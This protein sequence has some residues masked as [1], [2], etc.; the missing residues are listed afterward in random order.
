MLS[1]S[2]LFYTKGVGLK[3]IP[4]LIFA[5]LSTSLLFVVAAVGYTD[6]TVSEA[7]AMIDSDP[8]LLILDVRNQSEYYSGH[9]REARLIPVYDLIHRLEEL[10][11]ND[12][13]LVYS[14]SGERGSAASQVLVDNGFLHV[15]NL[16]GG[17]MDWKNSG[18]D[19]YVRYSSIQEAIDQASE[20]DT[21]HISS[22]TYHGNVIVDKTIN[23]VGENHQTTFVS[24]N[25]TQGERGFYILDRNV[26]L[27][28]FTISSGIEG[29]YLAENAENCTIKDCHISQNDV[30]IFVKS[31]HNLFIRNL[32]ANNTRSGI[33]MYA[34]CSCSPVK[35][36]TI[37]GNTLFGN[38]HGIM[39]QNANAS[40]I[41]HNNFVQ[42]IVQVICSIE[43]NTWDD[44]Y[45]S[46][47]NYW[48]DYEGTDI[49]SG[50]EQDQTGGDGIG[51]IPYEVCGNREVDGFPL[52]APISVFHAGV[53]SG[54]SYDV[55]IISNSSITAFYF[56]PE[57]G[58]FVQFNVTG[59]DGTVGF[60]TLIMPGDLLWDEDE[61][62]VYIDDELLIPVV[63]S[64]DEYTCLYIVYQHSTKTIT[65]Y[66][67]HVI[68]EFGSIVIILSLI[69]ASMLIILT[70]R[71]SQKDNM[72]KYAFKAEVSVD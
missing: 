54:G 34:S 9:I 27:G 67:D 19:V 55:G 17:I 24:A 21:I 45:P 43:K 49:Y 1:E 29:I 70:K 16:A 62:K 37:A 18:Y 10:D 11:V 33:E 3:K 30:G 46:S 40:V 31:S 52:I 4:F 65:I 12:H 60:S 48:T 39:M 28:S 25:W 68:Q 14:G 23:L 63:V 59:E 51:D 44:G 72:I 20:G 32:I 56:Y 22:G 53:W 57:I 26:S 5:L 13:I 58:P 71:N 7:K 61:W 6:V 8:S 41:Y 64:K 35:G 47:G 2:K 42:N 36:N 38:D 15:Y 69:A 66:G 50:P